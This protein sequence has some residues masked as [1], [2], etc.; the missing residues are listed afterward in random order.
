VSPEKLKHQAAHVAYLN[1]ELCARGERPV[2][3]ASRLALAVAMGSSHGK[4]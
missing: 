4:R 1:R 2:W 3:D